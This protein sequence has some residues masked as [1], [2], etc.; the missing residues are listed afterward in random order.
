MSENLKLGQIIVGNQQKDAVHVAVA[1]VIANEILY[2]AQKIAFVNLKLNLVGPSNKPIGIVDPF[3]QKPVNPEEQ[4]WM[5]L[6]PGSIKSLRHDWV[7]PAFFENEKDLA[8]YWLTNFAEKLGYT[9]QHVMDI[10]SRCIEKNGSCVGDDDAQDIFYKNKEEFLK[11]I[12]IMLDVPYS[13]DLYDS[14]YFT[15]AC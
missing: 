3:L 8:K 5:F 4:F 12:A 10:G 14:V 1:P 9:F 15:C 2:P 11:N 6:N 13:E 7:H